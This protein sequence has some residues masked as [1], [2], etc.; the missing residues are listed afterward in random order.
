MGMN[1]HGLHWEIRF[2][3]IVENRVMLSA[4]E[5]HDSKMK[6]VQEPIYWNQEMKLAT[7]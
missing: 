5:E 6:Y 2:L 7:S 1:P 3:E 4:M